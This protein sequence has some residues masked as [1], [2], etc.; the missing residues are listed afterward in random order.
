MRHPGLRA[1]VTAGF[2]AGALVL[3][4]SMAMLSY[5]L[6]R[7][8]LLAERERLAVRAAYFDATVLQA[9]LATGNP[10]I[11]EVLGS[12]D[13]GESRRAVLRRNGQWYA[14]TA[15]VDVQQAV[16]A[17]LQRMVAQSR[18]GVQRIRI[19]GRPALV[20]GV[21]VAPAT[22][23]YEVDSLDELAHAISVLGLILTSVA[24]A[25]AA[26]GAALGWYASRRV[27]RPL[28]SVVLA[29]QEIAA[30]DLG[31]RLD[32]AA[33]P[34]LQRLTTSFNHMVDQLA[35]RVERDRRFAADVSHELRS[36]LQTL[37]AAASVLVGRQ[38]HLDARTA[39]AATLV[40]D[41]VAR[42]QLLVT[43]LIELARADT[44]PHLTSVNLVELATQVCRTRDI[45]ASVIAE[46]PGA[47]AIW[48]VDR[49]RF[50][51]VLAN[52]LDNA[53]RHGG[54]VLAV[55]IG[56]GPGLRYLEV[57]DD[58]PGVKPEDREAVFDRFVRGPSTN[59][60]GDSPGTGL[61]LALVSQHV[62]AHGGRVTIDDRPG[63]GARFRVELPAEAP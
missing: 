10:D 37:S 48:S 4:A 27:L 33:E 1:R 45:P 23:L 56:R 31:A 7:R 2:A 11:K 58:G 13:T 62:A 12:L 40:A 16:P 57:D 44:P 14:S 17:S 36:P 32:P 60:R 3:S 34:D 5:E 21:P 38:A 15:A 54:G 55:R 52:L 59:A 18:P 29:A 35:R 61:G 63:G 43:D 46:A 8:S 28:S 20:I 25:T 47:E 6:T 51:Q 26:A 50:A 19:E 9:G 41:E 42:F 39:T 30:G 24:V 22:V 53:Q 49:R